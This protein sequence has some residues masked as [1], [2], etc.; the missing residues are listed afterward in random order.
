MAWTQA[1]LQ[2]FQMVQFRFNEQSRRIKAERAAK[3]LDLPVQHESDDEARISSREVADAYFKAMGYTPEYIK[4][5]T[6]QIAG[7]YRKLDTDRL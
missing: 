5:L 2:N 3:G 7:C 6:T 1:E 4:R